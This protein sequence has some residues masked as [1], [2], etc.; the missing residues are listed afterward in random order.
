MSP[1]P[2]KTGQKSKSCWSP[3]MWEASSTLSSEPDVQSSSLQGDS[4]ADTWLSVREKTRVVVGQIVVA[5]SQQCTCLQCP[6]CLVVPGR[7]EHHH[8]GTTYSPD[9]VPCGI[10]LFPNLKGITERGP[11]LK[12]WRPSRR[13]YW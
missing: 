3:S 13:T 7:D 8:T 10:F 11:I 4:A 2:K 9:L 6:E 5:S 12:A 1:R